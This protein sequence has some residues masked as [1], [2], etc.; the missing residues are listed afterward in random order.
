MVDAAPHPLLDSK[1][2]RKK[3]GDVM[4][5]HICEKEFYRPPHLIKSGARFCSIRCA[6]DSFLS[7]TVRVCETCGQDFYRPRSQESHR[8]MGRFCSKKC[9]GAHMRQSQTGKNNPG[10]KGGVSS[11]NRRMRS[12]AAFREW[13]EAVFERDN[14]TCVAC[15]QRGGYLEPDHIKPFAYFPD[16]RFDPGNGRT[17]CKPCHKKTD[18]YGHKAKIKYGG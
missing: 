8:G 18:T 17:M 10:W 5:C 2:T 6:G 12:S 9:K 14:Y 4:R 15:G 7:G 11:E 1:G 3:S 16:L 13:R